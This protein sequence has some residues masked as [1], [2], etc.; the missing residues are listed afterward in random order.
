MEETGL[1]AEE[2]YKRA[3]DHYRRR[4]RREELAQRVAQEQFMEMATVPPS[5]AIEEMIVEER[6]VMGSKSE[7]P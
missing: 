1:S 7:E 5:H 2:A 4:R 6:K 3:I